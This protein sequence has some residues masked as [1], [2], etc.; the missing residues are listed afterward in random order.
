M[1]E[2]DKMLSLGLEKQ[3]REIIGHLG[4]NP[5]QTLLW[6]ATLPLAVER[7]ARSAVMN[8]IYI[9]IGIVGN[10][11]KNIEQDII[12]M[13]SY[14]KPNQLLEQIRLIEKPPVLI[15]CNST[16]SVDKVVEILKAEQFHVAG[17]HSEKTQPHRSQVMKAFKEQ[18]LD[19]L[20][21]T[22][23]AS[24]GID[25]KDVTA[26][27]IYDMPN[28]IEDYI[29]RAGRTGRA[30]QLGRAIAFLTFE[31]TIAAE[32][33]EL[34]KKTRQKMPTELVNNFRS[35]GQAFVKT[36]YGDVKKY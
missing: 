4:D 9:R 33:K 31:C 29:H 32:L 8:P 3:L 2:V 28:T 26:V 23:I 12:F 22:D 36:D 7:L 24:R 11:N 13:H 14:Q 21:A 27:I 18:Q 6:S 1:D 34:L 17:L 5:H 30:G 15:F 16:H 19:V 35:F 10:I 25:V 20:V